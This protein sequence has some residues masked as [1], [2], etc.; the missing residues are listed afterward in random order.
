MALGKFT[1]AFVAVETVTHIRAFLDLLVVLLLV[2]ILEVGR[3]GNNIEVEVAIVIRVKE[4]GVGRV[5]VVIDAEFLRLFGEGA[6]AVVYIQQV[7]ALFGI[8]IA[9]TAHVNVL[10]AIL[11][12]I[13]HGNTRAPARFSVDAAFCAHI[14]ELQV[15]LVQV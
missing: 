3:V 11:I 2:L 7:A 12:D 4:V 14:L 6:V 9:G 15:A 1:V 10:P 8:F 5:A 13:D